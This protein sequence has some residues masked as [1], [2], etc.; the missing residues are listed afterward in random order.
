MI[1]NRRFL[2][3]L[4]ASSAVISLSACTHD[5]PEDSRWSGPVSGVRVQWTAAPEIDLTE[6]VAV[7][8]R[9]YLESYHSVQ[10]TGSLAKA[11][12]GFTDAVPPN[13]PEDAANSST[14]ARRP[15]EDVAVGSQLIGDLKF[16]LES[17]DASR[18]FVDVIACTYNYALGVEHSDG[19][20]EQLPRGGFAQDRGIYGV[21]ISLIPPGSEASSPLPPQRGPSMSPNDNVFQEWRVLGYLTTTSSRYEEWPD[22]DDVQGRCVQSAPD[23]LDRRKQLAKGPQSAAAF[24]I[25]PPDPGWPGPAPQ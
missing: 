5:Q 7:P 24:P 16:S 11:Y 10:F 13:E 8:V 17:I 4:L 25:S 18:R 1:R 20:F 12:P 9:A 2:V 14:L 19:Q 21:R 3:T 23:P 6:G 15:N 22:K